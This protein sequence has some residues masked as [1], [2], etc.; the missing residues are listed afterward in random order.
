M[1][2]TNKILGF[3]LRRLCN[4]IESGARADNGF[5]EKD[6]VCFNSLHGCWE[7]VCCTTTGWR[8]TN[9]Q[10]R[11][12]DPTEKYNQIRCTAPVDKHA[13]DRGVTKKC[14]TEEIKFAL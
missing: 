11:P 4:L 5:K 12:A 8:Q 1:R 7:V 2:W 6:D 14:E 10:P 9:T 3:V 13:L